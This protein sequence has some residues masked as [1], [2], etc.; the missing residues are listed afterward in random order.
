MLGLAAGAIIVAG[1]V[2]YKPPDRL[3]DEAVGAVFVFLII[4]PV[5][6]YALTWG[7]FA[8]VR[9]VVRGFRS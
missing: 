5:L 9:W 6:L 3:W 7:T 8:A 2:L 1:V 4:L